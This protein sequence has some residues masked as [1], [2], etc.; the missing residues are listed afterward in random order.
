MKIKF[1]GQEE[2]S[3]PERIKFRA[4]DAQMSKLMLEGTPAPFVILPDDS[5]VGYVECEPITDE[6]GKPTTEAKKEYKRRLSFEGKFTFQFNMSKED[7]Q[8]IREKA[9]NDTYMASEA[10]IY[11]RKHLREQHL[12]KLQEIPLSTTI[13][14]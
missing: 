9:C 6:E 1:K 11:A 3:Q 13:K 12:S 2:P 14:G 10:A 5:I 4:S 8:K 7:Y